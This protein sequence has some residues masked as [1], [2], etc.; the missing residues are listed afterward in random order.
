MRNLRVLCD[1]FYKTLK[2]SQV[3]KPDE[4]ALI[5]PNIK[6]MLDVHMQFNREMKRI[7][8]E[9]PLVSNLG[10][11]LVKMF[12]GSVGE[13]LKKA[14]AVF[15]ERQ[16]QALE[17]IK[18]R[19]KRDS[20]FDGVLVECEKKRQCRRLPLQGIVPTEMQR[21]SKYPLLLERLISSVEANTPSTH[22][23]EELGKLKRAH[24]L[25]KDILN[26]VNEAAKVAFNKSRLDD[27]QRHLDT[28]NFERSASDQSIPQEFKDFKVKRKKLNLDHL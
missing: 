15:C 19:R 5:F 28:T 20:K 25:S 2:E 14:A 10:D 13:T 3:L 1:I 17:F 18:E 7:R 26:H 22:A 4:I 8:R 11:M 16:Q 6:E 24:H 21:L 12:G 23:Q 27:I 9:D